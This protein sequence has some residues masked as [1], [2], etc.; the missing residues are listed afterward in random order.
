MPSPR[1][2]CAGR[3]YVATCPRATSSRPGSSASTRR[4]P[5]S[6]LPSSG[7]APTPRTGR[8]CS[9][10]SSAVL[11]QGRVR[12]GGPAAAP[13]AAGRRQPDA[14]PTRRDL[15]AGT[16][17]RADTHPSD[18]L[19]TATGSDPVGAAVQRHR[20]AARRSRPRRPP[21]TPPGCDRH[22]SWPATDSAPWLGRS[23]G[24]LRCAA[25]SASRP[26][27][28]EHRTMSAGRCA[29][30]KGLRLAVPWPGSPVPR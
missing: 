23:S 27:S 21:G 6:S 19:P 3:R 17:D 15:G 8:S 10:G 28:A 24:C 12:R 26:P 2:P 5:S 25:V 18:R 4:S 29:H 20:P 22:W 7:P 13:A 1:R 11:R 30:C 14:A 9:T 16:T